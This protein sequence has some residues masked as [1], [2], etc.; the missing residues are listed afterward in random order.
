M[1]LRLLRTLRIASLLALGTVAAC[2]V[3]GETGEDEQD[4]TSLSARQRI[5]KFEGVVYVERGIADDEILKM[6]HRQTRTAFGALLHSEVAAQT[7]E[8]QNVQASALKK[9]DVVVVTPETPGDPGHEMTEVRYTY[10]DNALVPVAMSRKTSLS[11][12]LLGQRGELKTD[13]IVQLC[14]TND[15][16]ARDDAASGLL[17]YDFDPQR[18]TCRK[19]MEKEQKAIDVDT[20]KLADKSTM[21]AASR[22]NRTYLPVTMQLGRADTAERATF[23]E[24][25]RLFAGAS[26]PGVLTITF[27]TGR[28]AHT[29]IEARKDGGYFEW[30]STLDVLF[31]DHPEFAL[32]KI[33]PAENLSTISAEGRKFTNLSFKDFINWTVRG[34]GFPEG[35]PPSSRDNIKKTV[36]S[37]LD[38]HWVTFEKK[39]KVSIGGAEPKDLTIRLETLFGA[40]EDPT[41]HKRAMKRG[42]VFVYNG[43]SYIGEGPL[44]PEKFVR[45]DFSRGYQMFWFDSCVSY[46]Y[47]EKDFFTLKA[48]GSKD[49]ELITNGLEAPEEDSGAA[50]GR[51]LSKLIDGSTPSYQT[52]LAAAKSTDSLRV[53]DGE[54]DNTFNPSQKPIR[55]IR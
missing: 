44:D 18:A 24:Y 27:I 31:T 39:T 12:A 51:L 43:H 36:A 41:P 54:I 48:N 23:P 8:F 33:E 16:E 34:N 40:E 35:M 19:A 32:T 11:L 9:R 29:K 6:V 22:L 2:A 42:D 46:N 21:V 5:L 13:E 26:E 38:M 55:I 10:T 45:E 3:E 53:V 4:L 1:T 20:E 14:T 28:L 37:K 52:L 15:K 47:Y 17:W 7:R 50:E 49:L 30:L 25:D